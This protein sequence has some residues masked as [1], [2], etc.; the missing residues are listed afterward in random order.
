MGRERL[1]ILPIA[2]RDPLIIESSQGPVE[3]FEGGEFLFLGDRRD[4]QK[5]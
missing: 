1:M 4:R 2:E 3:D 5:K